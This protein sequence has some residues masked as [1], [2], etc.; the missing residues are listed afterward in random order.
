MQNKRPLTLR[1]WNRLLL[2]GRGLRSDWNILQTAWQVARHEPGE[3]KEKPV[4][5][6]NASTRIFEN[7]L[8]AAYSLIASW[9]I[10]LAGIPVIHF[11]CQRG[12]TNCVL[13]T[14]RNHPQKAMPCGGC[15]RR[16]KTNYYASRVRGFGYQNAPDL[17]R[18]LLGLT[19]DQLGV[20]SRPFPGISKPIPLGELVTPALRWVLRRHNLEDNDTTR[21]LYR[22]FILSAWNIAREFFTMLVQTEPRAVIVFNGQFFPEAAAGWVARN[23]GVRVVTH[24][25]GLQPFTGFFTPGEA[26]AYPVHIPDTFRLTPEQNARLDAYLEERFQGQF[27]MAGIRFW[28]DIQGLDESFL[29]KAA[30]F[31]QIVPVFTNVIF[32]TSQPHANTVFP[33]MFAWLYVLVEI[34]CRFPKTLFVI[35]AHPDEARPGKESQESVQRWVDEHQVADLPNVVFIPPDDYV[36]S[37]DLIRRSKFVMIYNSTIGLEASILGIPVLSGG[38]ARFTQYPTVFFPQSVD[39]FKEMAEDFLMADSIGVPPEFKQ[40]SRR[41]LY[42]QLFRVSLPFEAFLT[43]SFYASFTRLKGFAWKQLLPDESPTARVIL[44]GILSNGEFLL[45]E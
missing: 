38:K 15:I 5:F 31:D 11:V 25:I 17:E 4:V 39:E 28:P 12:M 8:N 18:E 24:E 6:F 1:A 13:G 23:L 26:T 27:S 2:I 7:S 10:R 16:S 43:T 35:R 34:I 32:D 30:Q 9:M 37:Y 20:F 41:F 19:L 33:D 22:A 29:Q 21:Y 3:S 44:D 42:Y 14:K 45:K 40:N 36:S